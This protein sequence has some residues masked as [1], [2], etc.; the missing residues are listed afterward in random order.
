MNQES[1]GR[2]PWFVVLAGL[3][4]A[5]AL[6]YSLAKPEVEKPENVTTVVPSPSVI[7]AVRELARLEGAVFHVERVVDL[8]E[9]QS[10][11][12][13]LI[14]AED[15]ILLVAAGDVV[16]GVDLSQLVE[17]DIHADA[18]G[19]RV[20]LRLPRA[21]V[22]GRHIDNER[23]YVHTRTTGML[24]TRRENLETKARQEAERTLEK[25]ALDGGIL[26]VAE[27]SVRRTVEGLLRSLGFQ[28]VEVEFV[29]EGP[30]SESVHP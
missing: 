21:V 6:G 23:T 24:A 30:P 1:S 11:F 25:A 15:A 13:G 18:S 4:L 8:K 2:P 26:R 28:E 20:S 29:G 22:L 7:V 16:A 10:K 27:T 19:R 17:A 5:G 12:M 3:G 14:Q 9:T